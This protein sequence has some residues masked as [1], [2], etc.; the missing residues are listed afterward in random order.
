LRQ[1]AFPYCC[2]D[3]NEK[4]SWERL[5]GTRP[6]IREV[7]IVDGTPLLGIKPYVPRFDRRDEATS[8]WLADNLDR[9]E[10]ARDDSRFRP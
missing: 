4:L 6:C 1:P 2:F 7:D 3:Q 10:G 5:D 9:L 8:G